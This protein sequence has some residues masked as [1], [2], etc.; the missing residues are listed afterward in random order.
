VLGSYLPT[1]RFLRKI[2][3][4]SYR[5]GRRNLLGRDTVFACYS[6]QE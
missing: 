3:Y 4:R 6:S 1:N 5:A 2:P